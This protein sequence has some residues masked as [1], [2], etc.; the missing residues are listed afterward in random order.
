MLNY[1]KHF[2]SKRPDGRFTS[3]MAAHMEEMRHFKPLLALPEALT[4]ATFSSYREEVK[5]KLRELLCLPEFTPQPAPVRLFR[6]KRDGYRIEKWEFY[7]DDYTA[8]PF[9]MLVPDGVSAANPAPGVLCLPG[10]NCSKE[11]LAGEARPDHPNWGYNKFVERNQQALHMVRN[12]MVAFAF[13]NPGIGECAVH[14]DPEA[15]ETQGETRTQMCYGFLE[16]GINYVGVA[17]FQ[18]LCFMNFLRSLDFVDQNRLAVSAH[19]LGT[20][21]AIAF[22]LLCDDIKALVFNDF[23][24]DDRR[25][26]VSVTEAPENAMSQNIGLW[27]II[28]GKMRYFGFQDLCA[29]FAPR[30]LALT[31]GGA[32][33]F[34]NT[35]KRAY[36]ACGVPE[37]LQ[38]SFYPA[39]TDPKTRT[40][41]GPVPLYGL[42]RAD[43]YTKYSYVDVP[44][45]SFRPEAALR[46]LRDCFQLEI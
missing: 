40:M 17:V 12:D 19:S 22:G 45:H 5:S 32:E 7:P 13:D 29:A 2:A 10:S 6:E 25:R 9:L 30:H 37:R 4:E 46:I 34:L 11:L 14:T 23:L 26:Y 16:S 38:I 24:H 39:Y 43:F 15:G 3:T 31:E 35:V 21:T 36:E 42:S 1:G 28:P 44:D 20:E 8:V 33:E 27:H 18:K 41:H